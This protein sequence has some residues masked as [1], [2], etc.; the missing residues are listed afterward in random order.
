MY[1]SELWIQPFFVLI[2]LAQDDV[3]AHLSTHSIAA[4]KSTVIDV[5]IY[6]Q[7]HKQGQILWAE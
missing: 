1:R 3:R 6:S 5:Q 4:T 2:E 7:I